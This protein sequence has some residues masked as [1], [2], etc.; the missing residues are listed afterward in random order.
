MEKKIRDN[1]V[2]ISCLPD[3]VTSDKIG[4]LFGS[5]G[6]IKVCCCFLVIMI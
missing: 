5:I 6:V 3:D 1:A 2:Y 4:E